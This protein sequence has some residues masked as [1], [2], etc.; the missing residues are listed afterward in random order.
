M[1]ENEQ[2]SCEQVIRARTLTP[3]AESFTSS[4]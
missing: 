2:D 1:F 3:K 4:L